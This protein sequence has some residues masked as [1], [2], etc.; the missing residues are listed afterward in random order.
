[1]PFEFEKQEIPDVIL[2]KP[3]VFNDERGFFMET[4]KHSDF[5][6]NG[7]IQHFTQDNHS[8]SDKNI[9]RGL[10]F[11]TN[12]K[13]QAKILRCLSGEIYDIAVDLRKNSPTYKK[14]VGVILSEENKYQLYIPEGFAHGFL[15]LSEEAEVAYKASNEYSPKHDAGIRW[16]DPQISIDWR[17]KNPLVSEKD[18]N[19]PFLKDIE[20]NF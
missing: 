3:R 20:I 7:I 15:V 14:W 17:I 9:L 4:Y 13:S 5:V 8:K 16:N 18:R 2:I 11:Q 12:P 10:H 6:A 19:L 1:M